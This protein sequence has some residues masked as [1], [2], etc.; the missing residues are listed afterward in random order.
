MINV[1][2]LRAFHAVATEGSFSKAARALNVGQPTLSSQVKALEAGYGV[3]L[4]DRRGRG[5]QLTDLGRSLAEVTN[6]LTSLQEEAEALLSGAENLAHGTLTVGAD[7]PGDAMDLLAGLRARHPGLG[8]K[9]SMGN[10]ESVLADLRDYRVDTALLSNVPIDNQLHAIPF[11]RAPLVMVCRKDH[12]LA[13]QDG[14]NHMEL[15]GHALVLRE[16]RSVTR[17]LFE[18]A[19]MRAG[20]ALTDVLEVESREAVRAAV[21]AGLGAGI[22]IASEHE[23]HGDL[24]T[25]PLGPVPIEVTE[26]A[27]CLRGRRRLANIKAFL[28]LARDMGDAGNSGG[29]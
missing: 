4:F 25:V 9:I 16:R 7:S 20:L 29:P 27:V 11:R 12:P 6:R 15:A 8:L 23:P 17:D 3:R 21:I 19:A 14:I 28:D 18:R 5:V 10:M 13:K 24:V 1:T 2:H 26:Y 22:V